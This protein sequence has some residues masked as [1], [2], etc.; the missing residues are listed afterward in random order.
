M[1][2]CCL[3]SSPKK[4]VPSKPQAPGACGP[5]SAPSSAPAKGSGCHKPGIITG[6]AFLNYMRRKRMQGCSHSIVQLAKEASRE[7]RA[8]SEQQKAPY[9]AEA[10][11]ARKSRP[12]KSS[13]PI[14]SSKLSKSAPVRKNKSR[15]SSGKSKTLGG[16]GR[17]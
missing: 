7:W 16:G 6:S 8:M 5:A 2:D 4:A 13:K 10:Q 3:F 12:N 15:K 14:K 1:I 9:V 17:C 11:S